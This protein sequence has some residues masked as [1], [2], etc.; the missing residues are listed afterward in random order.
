MKVVLESIGTEKVQVIKVVREATGWGLKEAKDFVDSVEQNGPQILSNVR[1][2]KKNTVM[3]EFLEAGAV[4]RSDWEGDEFMNDMV[5]NESSKSNMFVEKMEDNLETNSEEAGSYLST[6]QV[7]G[8]QYK[9][10]VP[11]NMV[12]R[13]DRE[14]TLKV[15]LEVGK[16]AKESED[17]DSEIAELT[18]QKNEQTKM[19]DG[20]R[21]RV[22]KGAKTIIWLVT[23][24]TTL[25]G[26]L[27]GGITALLGIVAYIVMNLTVKKL[28]L[29]KHSIEN[30]AKAD[31]YLAENV[32]P[33]QT[34]LDEVYALRE[35]LYRGGK[36]DWA[37]DV[38]GKDLFYSGCIHDLYNI[39]K[40]R[41][42]DNLKEALNK[43][44]DAQHQA[45]MEE[46]QSAIQNA[47]EIAATE[48]VKQTAYTQA[49]EKNTHQAAT[50]AK[51]T[52]YH[53]RQIDKNTRQ[54]R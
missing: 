31:A 13:L 35:E 53:T 15:L 7:T 11:S 54:S 39:I 26:F 18:K 50:A 29:K 48:A 1:D 12:S 25:I 22:S 47:S 51:A 21:K 24:G 10:I 23:L 17:Y 4:A 36:R 30:N 27:A 46:M 28:D 52:A 45:R 5:E 3:D 38:V 34:R 40:S 42:A 41:R 43:Y 49:I 19:A 8:E 16:I 9:P 44:D 33:L 2:E 6:G 14:N 37:V 32:T 20:L